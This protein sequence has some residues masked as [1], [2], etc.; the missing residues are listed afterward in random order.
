MDARQLQA[1]YANLPIGVLVTGP[2]GQVVEANRHV[3]EMFGLRAGDDSLGDD[4][5]WRLLR[6]DGTPM[7]DAETPLAR[8][9]AGEAVVR[10]VEVGVEWDGEVQW[11]RVTAAAMPEL[12]GGGA[13]VLLE[14]VTELHQA[15][16]RRQRWQLLLERTREHLAMASDA[17]RLTLWR[18]DH[19]NRESTVVR[20]GAVYD[21]AGFDLA[22]GT[23][24]PA[25][26]LAMVVPSQR[27]EY[28]AVTTAARESGEPYEISFCIQPDEG[29]PLWLL[30]RGQPDPDDPDVMLGGTVDMTQQVE[31][32][33]RR[34]LAED[35][36][37]T[38]LATAPDVI[39]QATTDGVLQYVSPAVRE[40][41]GRN[42]EALVGQRVEGLVATEAVAAVEPPEGT[43]VERVRV[44]RADGEERWLETTTRATV[45]PD[46]GH[47]LVSV[48]RDV[49]DEV[50]AFAEV[51]RLRTEA[52]ESTRTKSSF[53]ANISHEIRTPMN[54]II[55][56]TE[57]TL[58]TELAPRQ[59][60]YVERV[61]QSAQSLMLIINDLLD[62]SKFEAGKLELEEV[63][64]R[65]DDVLDGFRTTIGLAAMGR[66][67]E[68][69]F[70]VDPDVP[71]GLRGDPLRLGQVLN[72]L[73]SNAVKFTDSGGEVVLDVRARSRTS[74][75]VELV[76]RVTDTG[77]GMTPAQ[78]EL[79]F[80]PFTQADVSTTRS[81][82]GTGLG[83][84][85]V[86]QL[87]EQMGGTVDVES[88]AGRGSVFEVVLPFPLAATEVARLRDPALAAEQPRTLVVDDRP[89]ARE[90]H[91]RML[92][93]LGLRVDEAVDGHEAIAMVDAAQE[94]G[95]PYDLLLVDWRMPGLDGVQLVRRLQTDPSAPPAVVMVTA[96]DR[97]QAR[98]AAGDV[99]I[100]DFLEKPATPSMLHDAIMD[101]LGHDVFRSARERPEERDVA[102]IA[103]VLRGASILLVE[104]NKVNQ[105]L[106]VELLEREGVRVTVARDGREA[107]DVLD[108]RRF[109]AILMDCQLPVMDGY[110]AT[111]RLRQRPGLD[112]VPVIAM[113]ANAMAADRD[114][115]LDAG[116]DD[117]IAKP[118]DV[119]QLWDTLHR[120]V[121]GDRPTP[122][123]RSADQ[124]VT[125]D[126]AASVS[127]EVMPTLDGVDTEEGLRVCRGD[128]GL[129]T[130]LLRLVGEHHTDAGDR[131]AGRLAEDD[132]DGAREIAHALRGVAANVRA[133]ALS[134]AAG[135]VEEACEAGDGEAAAT[136][137]V[138]VCAHLDRLVAWLPTLPAAPPPVDPVAEDE[139]GTVL[140][141]LAARIDRSDPEAARL[142]DEFP[143]DDRTDVA[144]EHHAALAEALRQYDFEAAAESLARLREA[145]E[146]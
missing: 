32:Q 50:A 39:S 29:Q 48:T 99:D 122:R 5:T 62:Y 13:V 114:R 133:K 26:V 27:D 71:L 102:S 137:L 52:E 38:V 81:F 142:V 79:L 117:H 59:R 125:A 64:F 131:I 28:A 23:F 69:L 121:G 67:V 123:H 4:V 129:Y 138:D 91:G 111:R 132:L 106:A 72:N 18:Y 124:D 2:D 15:E 96:H 54:A 31:D 112:D 49:T 40:V 119:R 116:M 127:Y 25:D 55:G 65:L 6:A 22:A 90:I 76:F 120:W 68:L 74:A 100:V 61:Q 101:A 46:G 70:D 12:D 80:E 135:E 104:D 113:T 19:R 143:V 30:E 66:G 36:L 141:E 97:A 41:L 58:E 43:A 130:R 94:A 57:L 47:Q 10:D 44:T 87:V 1:L 3:E 140:D 7:P 107:L 56:M 42:P 63:D 51:E 98:A 134:R 144:R 35:R 60:R 108:E 95:D 85:I 105:E 93:G 37:A 8:V 20:G 88:T 103:A 53:L 126:E 16:E 75:T 139:V 33:R 17:A 146:A 9:L 21:R 14:D 45:T 24:R 118:I 92:E 86:Q 11:L 128:V 83:L 110:E 73:G 145:V 89:T 77:I 136:A 84:A 34:E 115:V 109:D 78:L 82:G